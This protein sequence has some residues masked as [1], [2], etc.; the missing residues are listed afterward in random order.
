MID[1]I[2]SPFDETENAVNINDKNPKR[3]EISK[4]ETPNHW[5]Q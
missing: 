2:V 5:Q 3:L 1:K 4:M